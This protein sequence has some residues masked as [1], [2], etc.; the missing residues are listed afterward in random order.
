MSEELKSFFQSF[1]EPNFLAMKLLL[2][3]FNKMNCTDD[4][5]RKIVSNINTLSKY[6]LKLLS[7]DIHI[8]P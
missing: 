8:S 1:E 3:V 5:G 7:S 2:G 6:N 4:V